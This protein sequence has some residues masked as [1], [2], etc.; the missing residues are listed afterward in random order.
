[1]SENEIQNDA[2]VA[3]ETSAPVA[4]APSVSADA[5]VEVPEKFKKLVEQV[6]S[7]S[8]LELNELVKVLEKKFGVSAVAVAAAPAA[9]AGAAEES[10][11][12]TV[13]LADAGA[14]KIAVIKVVK[15]VLGL[16][17]KEAKDLVD[18]APSDIKTGVAK[19]EA[20]E[21]KAKFEE[22]GAKVTL[23]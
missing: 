15:E 20:D 8:V 18:A 2:V 19:A 17:L 7:M 1:M 12:F 13:V 22:A 16:G 10:S 4:D 23:K 11:T 6:E 21:L 9:G 5:E 3:E 14:Q